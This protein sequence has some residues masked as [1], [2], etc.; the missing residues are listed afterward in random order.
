LVVGSIPL[1]AKHIWHLRQIRALK[2]HYLSKKP[3]FNWI[4]K[5]F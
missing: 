5:Y 1:W 2:M 4:F 3:Q